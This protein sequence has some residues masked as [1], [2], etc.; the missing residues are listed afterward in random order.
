LFNLS[1]EVIEAITK[2]A[3]HELLIKKLE[4][5]VAFPMQVQTWMTR[6]VL[7]ASNLFS[8]VYKENKKKEKKG[9]V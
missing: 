3:N 1:D 4:S 9:E 7:H 2:I 5:S 6:R 8:E